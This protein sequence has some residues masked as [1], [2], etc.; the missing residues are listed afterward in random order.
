VTSTRRCVKSVRA[1]PSVV[2]ISLKTC[3]QMEGRSERAKL[4]ALIATSLLCNRS[5]E[6]AVNCFG[7]VWIFPPQLSVV[8]VNDDKE[9]SEGGWPG[10]PNCNTWKREM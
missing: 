1:T 10:L 2:W 8:I 3:K 5:V 6:F 9:Y 7:F 4:Q